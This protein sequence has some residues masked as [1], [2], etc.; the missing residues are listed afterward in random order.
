MQR[1]LSCLLL[2]GLSPSPGAKS[3]ESYHGQ[4]RKQLPFDP[5]YSSTPWHQFQSSPLPPPPTHH[6]PP[7]VPDLPQARSWS[8]LMYT[9]RLSASVKKTR[10]QSRDGNPAPPLRF[11]AMMARWN[12][13][14]SGSGLDPNEVMKMTAVIR[15]A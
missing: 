9:V 6:Y 12:Q 8:P 11:I 5:L 3:S 2:R 7:F 1:L 14:S 13:H 15:T 10:A 4:S